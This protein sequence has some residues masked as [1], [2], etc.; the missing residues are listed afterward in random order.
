MTEEEVGEE[1]EQV[2]RF[3]QCEDATHGGCDCTPDTGASW[4]VFEKGNGM[5]NRSSE[6]MNLLMGYSVVELKEV[7][8]RKT[9]PLSRP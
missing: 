7:R 4:K 6:D 8:G 2:G 5:A 9:S 1:V 3:G